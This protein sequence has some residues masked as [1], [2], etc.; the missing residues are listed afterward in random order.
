[1]FLPSN[2]IYYTS[3]RRESN[4]FFTFPFYSTKR[5]AGSQVDYRRILFRSLS[6]PLNNNSV[7]APFKS[8]YYDFAPVVQVEAYTRRPGF[9]FR[10]SRSMVLDT[11]CR[12]AVVARTE[13]ERSIDARDVITQLTPA[14]GHSLV[15]PYGMAKRLG[16]VTT[17][18]WISCLLISI[19]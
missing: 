16:F 9:Y 11:E 19:I 3:V 1:M 12:K 17:R 6:Q 14:R 8:R 7:E 18:Y 4:P 5:A 2:S 13:D 10:H 15:H